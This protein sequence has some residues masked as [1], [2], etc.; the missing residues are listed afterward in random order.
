MTYTC[1]PIQCITRPLKATYLFIII[2]LYCWR[3]FVLWINVLLVKNSDYISQWAD[4]E[5]S[6]SCTSAKSDPSPV[7]QLIFP[8]FFFLFLSFLSS[9]SLLSISFSC[10][11]KKNHSEELKYLHWTEQGND[12]SN[13]PK[14]GLGCGFGTTP[15]HSHPPPPP[16]LSLPPLNCCFWGFRLHFPSKVPHPLSGWKPL[17]TQ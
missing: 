16:P 8:F 2:I 14:Q 17:I 1:I 5:I 10:D 4:A 15:L 7:C 6:C 9:L 13:D 3:G 11:Q 12:L